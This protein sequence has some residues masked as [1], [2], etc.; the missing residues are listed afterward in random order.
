MVCGDGCGCGYGCGRKR[1][2]R[3]AV[4][5]PR[6]GALDT[7][8]MQ[9]LWTSGVR[10]QSQRWP[11]LPLEPRPKTNL[12][13]GRR[14]QTWCGIVAW[15]GVRGGAACQIGAPTRLTFGP[16]NE[17]K[18]C[19]RSV[20]RRLVFRSSGSHSVGDGVKRSDRARAGRF[21]RGLRDGGGL[22][23]EAKNEDRPCPRRRGHGRPRPR[24]ASAGSA[25][26]GGT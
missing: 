4:C 24:S 25:C 11:P 18:A 19:R 10:P 26:P 23:R 5:R 2:F 17:R 20:E 13:H 15:V 3:A 12:S 16:L 8:T 14:G 22:Q 7:R 6:L 9:P 1:G 21:P